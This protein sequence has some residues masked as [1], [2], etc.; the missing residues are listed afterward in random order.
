M[1]SAAC[2]NCAARRGLRQRPPPR[3]GLHR[4]P[5]HAVKHSLRDDANGDASSGGD[6]PGGLHLLRWVSPAAPDAGRG[7]EQ[8]PECGGEPAIQCPGRGDRGD[9]PLH[10]HGAGHLPTLQL[11]GP[12]ATGHAHGLRRPGAGHESTQPDSSVVK[13]FYHGRKTAT[14]TRWAAR[15]SVKPTRSGGCCAASSTRGSIA[16]VPHPLERGPL[17]QGEISIQRARPVG[18]SDRAGWRRHRPDLRPV[19]PEDGNDR[20]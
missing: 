7:G 12:A 19:G 18:G 5:P 3:A 16:A 17:R 14:L 11:D 2:W 15:R 6:L 10:G 13:T 9:G 4:P 8:Q 20:P 1:L